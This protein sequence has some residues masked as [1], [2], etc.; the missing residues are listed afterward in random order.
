M[1]KLIIPLF[2]PAIAL[3][4][5]VSVENAWVAATAPGQEEGA[6]YMELSSREGATL[7]GAQSPA[8]KRVD[9][10]AMSMRGGVMTMRRVDRVEIPPGGKVSLEPG[11]MHLMLNEIAKPLAPGG[12]VPIR[13]TFEHQ[14]RRYDV[15]VD[16]RVMSMTHHMDMH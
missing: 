2:F 9:V 10:H 11:K 14:G 16:A 7:I 3:A 13:L 5:P 6:A 15:E 12:S 8:A 4:A 1:K